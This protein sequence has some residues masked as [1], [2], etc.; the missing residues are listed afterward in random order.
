M[1]SV[2]RGSLCKLIWLEHFI[3]EHL[4]SE[5]LGL[6]LLGWYIFK[7]ENSSIL[8]PTVYRSDCQHLGEAQGLH[9]VRGKKAVG[10]FTQITSLPLL[11]HNGNIIPSNLGSE[12]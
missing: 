4:M 9:N 12:P 10:H 7:R 5:S 1:G 6:L 2:D 3:M 11:S 8:L